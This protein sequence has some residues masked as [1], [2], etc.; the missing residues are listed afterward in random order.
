MS[1]MP[2]FFLF[3]LFLSLVLISTAGY[4]ISIRDYIVGYEDKFIDSTE[5]PGARVLDLDS[6]GSVVV[7][8]IYEVPTVKSFSLLFWAVD[9]YKIE[10]DKA[11]DL[12]AFTNECDIYKKYYSDEIEWASIRDATKEYLLANKD[13][14]PTHFEFAIPLKLKDYDERKK[15][16]LLQDDYQISSV[17][18]FEVFARDF[19]DKPCIPYINVASTYPRSLVLEFSRP[20]SILGVPMTFDDANAYIKEKRKNAKLSIGGGSPSM[21]SVYFARNALLVLKVKI[22]THG[23]F[24]GVNNYRVQ[25][26]QM[27]A[28]LEG[29]DI[30][31]DVDRGNLLFSE[32]YVTKTNKKSVSLGLAE[33]IKILK[34]KAAGDGILH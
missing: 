2:R 23:R 28:V 22:F 20:L 26:V 31:D 33:Q 25:A 18:R 5:G 32:Q 29:Y 3:L 21:E 6:D 12:F 30:Y 17:R 4:A 9:L 15:I 8:T 11:V 24:L 16:F 13:D 1:F 14:F 10:D 34:A 27:L 19:S 7:N